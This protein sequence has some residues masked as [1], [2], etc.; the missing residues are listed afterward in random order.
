V[1]RYRN[2]H[3]FSPAKLAARRVCEQDVCG[4]PLK[5]FGPSSA[6]TLIFNLLEESS[7]HWFVDMQQ[8]ALPLVVRLVIPDNDYK[9]VMNSVYNSIY[10]SL[11]VYLVSPN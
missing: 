7:W 9:V 4:G 11:R 3:T 2:R 5:K 6:L 8:P 10:Y 1:A